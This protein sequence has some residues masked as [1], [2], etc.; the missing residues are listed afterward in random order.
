[1]G[2]LGAL[3][4]AAR[5]AFE[6]PDL[7][8]MQ[9]SW[10]AM[11]FATWGFAIALGVYAFDLGGATAVGVV[12]AV[13]LA[14]G[15]IATPFA[16]VIGDRH[17]RRLVLLGCTASTAAVLGLAGAAAALSAPAAIVYVLAGLFTV[18]S[19]PYIPAEGAIFPILARTPQE[20]SAANVARGVAD[21]L[22]FLLGAVATGFLLVAS[23]PALVFALTAGGGGG[24]R[25]W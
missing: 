17:S 12:A 25:P 19:S 2:R 14:P 4:R 6:N 11:S 22:G 16:G 1:M 8:R 10:A 21:N 20:L 24:R 5:A 13:R 9:V 23:G 3:L 18:V 15:V 7:G